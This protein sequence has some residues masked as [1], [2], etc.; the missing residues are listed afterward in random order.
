MDYSQLSPLLA[1]GSD[2]GESIPLE[3]LTQ[4]VA[5]VFDAYQQSRFGYV[6]AQ[7]PSLLRD[8]VA[9]T[10]TAGGDAAVRSG[11]LLA[12]SYQVTASVLTKLGEADLAWIAAES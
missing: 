4:R 2:G 5:S 12:L 10:R 8:A 11:E 7:A 6:T 9:V 3:Q 1:N